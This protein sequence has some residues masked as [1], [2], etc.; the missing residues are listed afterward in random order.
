LKGETPFSLEEC[1]GGDILSRTPGVNRKFVIIDKNSADFNQ[2]GGEIKCILPDFFK[3]ASHLTK[4]SLQY[5]LIVSLADDLFYGLTQL[6]MISLRHNN[7]KYL[8]PGLLRGLSKLSMIDLSDNLLLTIPKNFFSGRNNLSFVNIRM[9]SLLQIDPIWFTSLN[10]LSEF[11]AKTGSTISSS[12]L[13][14]ACSCNA[15]ATI[16]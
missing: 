10:Q 16:Y 14:S 3:G 8:P 13:H 4:I 5:N 9:D 11:V 7:I 6:E 1:S 12:S 15:N 2:G